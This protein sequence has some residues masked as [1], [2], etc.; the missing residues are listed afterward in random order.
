VVVEEFE[1][2]IIIMI[3]MIWTPCSSPKGQLLLL[4]F[5]VRFPDVLW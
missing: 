2:A 3:I 5:G 1:R 4:Q